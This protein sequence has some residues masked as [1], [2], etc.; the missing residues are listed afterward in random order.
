MSP[1]VVTIEVDGKSLQARKGAMLIEVTDAADIY[2]PRFCYHKKLT[3]A[4]NCR[5]CLVEVEKAPKPLPACATP[6]MDG[7]KVWTRSPRAKEAQ[8]STMEFLLINHPLDCPICDQGGECEL[9]DLAMGYGADISR[10][11]ERKRVVRDKDVG[12][13]IQTDMTRCIHCTR[14]VRFGDE[15][16]GIRELGATGRGEDMQIGTYIEQALVS[17]L[18][19]N[20]ID[21][22]PVGALTSKPFRFTARAW[23]LRQSEGIGPHDSIGSNLYLHVSNNRVRRVVPRENEAINEVWLS[24]RD[25]YSYLG[26]YSPD[27]LTV[28]MIRHDAQWR[29]VDWDTALEFAATGLRAVVE[30]HGAGQLAALA[31]ATATT[32]ECYLLQKLLRG[33]GSNNIDH[34]SLHSDFQGQDRAPLYPGLGQSLPELERR[35]AV[36]LI[37][38][39]VRKEQPLANHRLRKAAQRGASIAVINPVDFDFNYRIATKLIVR[40]ARMAAALAGVAKALSETSKLSIAP[41]VVEAL[42]GVEADDTQRA[43]AKHLQASAAPTVLLGNLA[44]T[45]ACASSLRALAALISELCGAT[46]GYLAEHA[47]TC[48]AWIAGAVPHRGPSG[49]PIAQAGLDAQAMFDP[50]VRAYLL[51]GIE[52]ELDCYRP[53]LAMRA[54]RNAEC[55]VSLSAYRTPR[56][57]TYAHAMLPVAIYA[58]NGG[59]LVNA[60]GEW[61]A[62]GAAVPPVGESR[63]AWKVLRVLGNRLGLAGFDYASTAEIA[64][65][66]GKHTPNTEAGVRGESNLKLDGHVAAG[67]D[68]IRYVPAYRHDALV[69]RAAA[70]QE[71]PDAGDR[72]LH[73]NPAVAR[74]LDLVEGVNVRLQNGEGAVELPVTLDARVPDD[75]VLIYTAHPAF[76]TLVAGT[77]PVSL[78]RL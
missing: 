47:N 74:R 41:D 5:M 77:A 73:I 12:A 20:V 54:L 40:P 51:L 28:P 61:Q 46:L 49:Q 17:E 1:D 9:Q 16:A 50:G 55:V 48:G 59:T 69:R 8:K 76:E 29:E 71:T 67:L 3:I 52:P 30:K 60:S 58:E 19:G 31:S 27:R 72:R 57:A 4:A 45:H 53:A 65:E 37:G 44:A 43:I 21:L 62:F 36:L 64:S 25:R 32:E 6:I 63:P 78:Q 11:S 42:A 56:M 68:L 13:L 70:L 39:N 33:L 26:L 18:S 15:V 2:V 75:C 35:D 23:E 7:M 38:S 66:L 22:C 10:Y 14:C 24:D 34:R